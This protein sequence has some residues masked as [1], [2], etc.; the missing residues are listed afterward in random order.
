MSN[1]SCYLK[2]NC[3][4]NQIMCF[5]FIYYFVSLIL[6]IHRFMCKTLNR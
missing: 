1:Q 5:F 4:D 2:V 6:K 3:V